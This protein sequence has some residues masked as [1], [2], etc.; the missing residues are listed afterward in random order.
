MSFFFVP[1]FGVNG[2][3]NNSVVP[4]LVGGSGGGNY[5]PQL[6]GGGSVGINGTSFVPQHQ[7]QQQLAG[8]FNVNAYYYNQ[9]VAAQ[10]LAAAGRLATFG[11]NHAAAMQSTLQ[12]EANVTGAP[13][14]SVN[15]AVVPPATAAA[16]AITIKPKAKRPRTE[17]EKVRARVRK[18]FAVAMGTYQSKPKDDQDDTTDDDLT[19]DDEEEESMPWDDSDWVPTTSTGRQKTPNEIRGA[20]QRYLVSSGRTQ[21]AVLED[22]KV[23]HCS[24]HK[25]MTRSYKNQVRYG[26]LFSRIGKSFRSSYLA[27]DGTRNSSRNTNDAVSMAD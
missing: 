5:A 12:Q 13:S 22:M 27:V 6:G 20:L 17:D 21:K 18:E 8:M 14:Q 10:Q 23:G 2:N 4:Q 9:L 7:Q 24:F 3:R 25:F 11:G 16:A 19:D 1:P 15:A 26:R